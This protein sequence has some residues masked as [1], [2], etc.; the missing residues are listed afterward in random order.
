MGVSVPDAERVDVHLKVFEHL[1]AIEHA[2]ARVKRGHD[3]RADEQR[4]HGL[5]AG[6]GPFPAAH[7]WPMLHGTHET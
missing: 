3:R 7:G 1:M 5:H 4:D 6:R 2:A